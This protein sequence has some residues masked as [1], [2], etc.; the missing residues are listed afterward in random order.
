MEGPRSTLSPEQVFR[1]VAAVALNAVSEERQQ[2]EAMLL[3]WENELAPGYIS[4][5]LDTISQGVAI[6]EVRAS[7]SNL[8]SQVS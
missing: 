8:Q 3:S 4:G 7:D 6:N 2:G 5:L 1:A